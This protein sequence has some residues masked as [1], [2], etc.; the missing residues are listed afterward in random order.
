MIPFC[1]S[2]PKAPHQPSYRRSVNENAYSEHLSGPTHSIW[3]G[4]HVFLACKSGG[5]ER[6]RGRMGRQASRC[7][8]SCSV[9]RHKERRAMYRKAYHSRERWW[10]GSSEEWWES[11][12]ENE[13]RKRAEEQKGRRRRE[14]ASQ[15][16]EWKRSFFIHLFARAGLQDVYDVT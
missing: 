12:R 1:F 7:E 11:L 6:K 13:R 15:T 14:R 4:T 10:V 16:R 5:R 2:P 8:L 9:R 3:R